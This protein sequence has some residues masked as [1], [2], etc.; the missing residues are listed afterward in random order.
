GQ[1]EDRV[2]AF[3]TGFGEAVEEGLDRIAEE[4]DAA[5]GQVQSQLDELQRFA[6]S[7]ETLASLLEDAEPSVWFV[8]TRDE[9][10]QPSVGS[11]FV[12]FA[13][14]EQSFLLASYT[15]VRAGTREP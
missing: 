2:E 3:E 1:T 14:S 8:A 4:R 6:A 10:G 11:A 5:V 13:D 7:G 9:A 12:V 15:T